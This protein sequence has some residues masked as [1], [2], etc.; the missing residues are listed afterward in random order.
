MYGTM[1]GMVKTTIYVPEELKSLLERTAR[2][3]GRSQAEII[4]E[5]LEQV[6]SRR[7]GAVPRIPLTGRGLGDPMA[8]ERV[9]EML[10]GFGR[11]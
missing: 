9:D 5:A 1:Y 8:A 3:E 10:R 11:E 7:R 6:L 2:R 4:R